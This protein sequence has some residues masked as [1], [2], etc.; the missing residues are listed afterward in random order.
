MKVHNRNQ[1]FL[2]DTGKF[3]SYGHGDTNGVNLVLMV[4]KIEVLRRRNKRNAPCVKQWNNWDDIA[5]IKRIKEIGC[6]APYY[7]YFKGFG[8]CYTKNEMEKWWLMVADIKSD[9]SNLPCQEMPRIDFEITD[10]L[11]GPDDVFQITIGY[12]E[13]VKLITQSRAV[14][15][16][17]LIG[18][19]G[20]YI[21]LFL[22][23]F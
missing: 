4:T 10:E 5:V 23:K 22:G 11:K 20:G 19:I 7:H 15:G 6:V 21:G 2:H 17:S 8:T 13:Q 9:Q 3:L 12:P 16:H 1:L 18:N 14:D